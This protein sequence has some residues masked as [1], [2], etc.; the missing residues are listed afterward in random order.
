MVTYGGPWAENYYYA[1][2]EVHDDPKVKRFVP[3]NII[4]GTRTNFKFKGFFINRTT[5]FVGYICTYMTVFANTVYF[6]ISKLLL[7]IGF[8]KI[9]NL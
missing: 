3:D 7:L 8:F 2:E 1:T 5:V 4:M 6:H 9:S